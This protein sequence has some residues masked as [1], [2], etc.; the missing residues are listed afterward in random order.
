YIKASVP[1]LYDMFISSIYGKKFYEQ[2]KGLGLTTNIKFEYEKQNSQNHS[3]GE[4]CLCSCIRNCLCFPGGY[5][6]EDIFKFSQQ[7]S[8]QM[9]SNN[10][11]TE[12]N[13]KNN[14]N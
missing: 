3:C 4:N 8:Q 14:A 13:R 2:V 5:S 9:K 11:D 10:S 12:F 6:V 1:V 7:F